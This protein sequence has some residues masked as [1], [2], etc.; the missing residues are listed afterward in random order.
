VEVDE[1]RGIWVEES[2]LKQTGMWSPA[3]KIDSEIER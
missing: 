1:G 2:S 3:T